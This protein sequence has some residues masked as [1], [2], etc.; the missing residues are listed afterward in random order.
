MNAL[1]ESRA[2]TLSQCVCS[3]YSMVLR[4]LQIRKKKTILREAGLLSSSDT[5]QEFRR[6]EVNSLLNL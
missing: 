5:R 3:I 1:P 4:K 2:Q 6:S